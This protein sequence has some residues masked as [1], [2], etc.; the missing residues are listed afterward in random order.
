MTP[1]R[2][3]KLLESCDEV[4]QVAKGRE[5]DFYVDSEYLA[6]MV[7]ELRFLLDTAAQAARTCEWVREDWAN[8]KNGQFKTSC[9][10]TI[11]TG[12]DQTR[13]CWCGRKVEV[14]K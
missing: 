8:F 10:M 13:P 7:S 12:H 6:F 14:K 1:A 11:H 2:I 5:Q 3:A 4:R 9:G